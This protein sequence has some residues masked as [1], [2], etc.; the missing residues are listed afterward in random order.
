MQAGLP[1]RMSRRFVAIPAAGVVAYSRMMEV[2]EA[3]TARLLRE[4]QAV[5]EPL[6]AGYG[7]RI[8]KTT[9]NGALIECPSV[10]GAVQYA[11]AFQKRMAEHNAGIPFHRSPRPQEPAH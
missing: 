2:D 8:V 1:D 10:V 4:H 5:A 11:V 6:V 3:G 7:E 9:G